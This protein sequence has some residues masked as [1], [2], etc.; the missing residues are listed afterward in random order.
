MTHDLEALSVSLDEVRLKRTQA[1]ATLTCALT[2]PLDG[3]QARQIARDSGVPLP[4]EHDASRGP[5]VVGLKMRGPANAVEILVYDRTTGRKIW[6]GRGDVGKFNLAADKG[7]ALQL[8]ITIH[9][10]VLAEDEEGTMDRHV[11]VDL[12]GH[13]SL[14][15]DV[16]WQAMELPFDELDRVHGFG[17]SKLFGERRIATG[18]VPP[19]DLTTDLLTACGMLSEPP[20]DGIVSLR[21]E[22]PG[23]DAA[24]MRISEHQSIHD[25]A[26]VIRAFDPDETLLTIRTP[27]GSATASIAACQL[28][29]KIIQLRRLDEEHEAKKQA[30]EDAAAERKDTADK[31]AEERGDANVTDLAERRRRDEDAKTANSPE[32]QD[33]GKVVYRCSE[34]RTAR[35]TDG[36]IPDDFV[37][38]EESGVVLCAVCDEAQKRADAEAAEKAQKTPP[39]RT[40]PA[41]RKRTRRGRGGT[42]RK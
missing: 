13:Q 37:R 6:E 30:A 8:G 31:E 15:L 10:C 20:E 12:V 19:E 42:G 3:A 2:A 22:C 9:E 34:C 28:A 14:A 7:F 16:A 24:T 25:A 4:E 33:R 36:E 41:A 40:T 5:R 26:P 17:F 23:F 38:D 18:E 11:F 35:E 39:E 1:S 32:G 29:L 21:F 27:A